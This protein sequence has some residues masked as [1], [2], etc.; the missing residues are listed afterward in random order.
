MKDKKHIQY[1]EAL[2][3]KSYRSIAIKRNGKNCSLIID[4]DGTPHVFVNQKGKAVHFN[5]LWEVKDWL[6]TKYAINTDNIEV[7]ITK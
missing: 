4:L 3:N 7:Q 6:N 5:N 1:E 2:L